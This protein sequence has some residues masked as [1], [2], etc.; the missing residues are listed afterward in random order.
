MWWDGGVYGYGWRKALD[1]SPGSSIARSQSPSRA[2]GVHK[3]H[4]GQ[5]GATGSLIAHDRRSADGSPGRESGEKQIAMARAG[6]IVHLLG[7]APERRCGEVI[8]ECGEQSGTKAEGHKCWRDVAG[9][10]GDGATRGRTLMCKQ[11]FLFA[12]HRLSAVEFI[13]A[14]QFAAAFTG[15]RW[16]RHVTSTV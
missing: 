9:A 8:T 13:F 11:F 14:L 4:C 2:K 3:G 15:I 10:H 7:K 6:S 12:W 1:C 16:T 5:S